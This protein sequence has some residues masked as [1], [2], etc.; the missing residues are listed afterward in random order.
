MGIGILSPSEENVMA[1]NS[2]LLKL[3]HWRK[4]VES[5]VFHGKRR[6][7]LYMWDAL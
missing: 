3:K 1:G 7:E 2:I 6:C 5:L 4:E